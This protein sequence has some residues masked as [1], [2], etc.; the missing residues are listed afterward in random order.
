MTG[1]GPAWSLVVEIAFYVSLPLLAA[2]GVG[3]ARGRSTRRGRRLAALA[4]AG[5]ML[6]L[7]VIGKAAAAFLVRPS[8]PYEGWVTDWHSVLERSVLCQADLFAFGMAL[9][10]VRIDS[11]DGLLQLPRWWR[12]AATFGCMSVLLIVTAFGEGALSYSPY[13]TLV[14]AACAL[15]L[16]LV[17]L[18]AGHSGRP[19]LV[20]LLEWPPLAAVG[21]V[22]Y[23]VFLWH[24]PLI[25]RLDA[26][27][28]TLAGRS[29]FLVDLGLVAVVT[30]IAS[31][32]TYRF[33]EAPALRLRFRVGRTPATTGI[34]A[35]DVDAGRAA[36]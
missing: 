12:Q 2:L 7:G 17:V 14:A 19:L 27:G 33:V 16:A 36:P 24:E 11:E 10:I 23:S 18:P 30:G 26:S 25:H 31:T 4:P 13:N 3:L 21:V 35:S 34:A 8:A 32:V 6:V 1:I 22:S 15:L 28:L 29:G 5:L 9:A 20:R